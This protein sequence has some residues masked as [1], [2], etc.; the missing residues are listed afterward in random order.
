MEIPVSISIQNANSDNDGSKAIP[1]ISLVSSSKS[2]DRLLNRDIYVM[3]AWKSWILNQ[4]VG[5]R[6]WIQKPIQKPMPPLASNTM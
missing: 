3:W 1:V 5:I 6:A 2:F 4:L